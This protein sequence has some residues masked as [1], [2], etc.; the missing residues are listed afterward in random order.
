[1]LD[2][3]AAGVR[4]RDPQDRRR[5]RRR[6]VEFDVVGRAARPAS[7]QE[8]VHTVQTERHEVIEGT[9]RLVVDGREHLLRAGEAME[10]P[11]GTPHR[12]LP[13][14]DGSGRVRVQLRPAGAPRFL[15]RLARM[16]VDAS[17]TAGATRGRVA[18]R[19][20]RARL[21]R[22]GPRPRPSLRVQRALSA[23]LLR[24]RLARV[25]V[26]RRVGRRGAARGGVRGARRRPQLPG[27]VAAGLRRGRGRDGEP[28]VGK[29]SRQHFKG[30]LPYHLHTRS[31]ITRLEPPHV[32]EADVD[33]DL[34][35]HGAGR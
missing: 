20:D 23:A 11:P 31:R 3:P 8:H 25:P 1:M 33:G 6:A 16:A 17:S 14:D 30:R 13:G 12:Q 2:I 24:A 10:V 35:G 34:R 32:I 28:A 26:R 4:D 15:R 27:L 9:M 5:D 7:P 21:R 18:R 22:R 29:E 19:R